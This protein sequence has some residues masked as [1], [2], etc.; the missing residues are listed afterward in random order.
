ML[1]RSPL[2]RMSAA[3]LVAMSAASAQ[4][5]DFE[6][7]GSRYAVDF[8]QSI[9]TTLLPNPVD[10]ALPPQEFGR[11]INDVERVFLNEAGDVYVNLELDKNEVINRFRRDLWAYSANSVVDGIVDPIVMNTDD[12]VSV[13]PDT[14]VAP[15]PETIFLYSQDQWAF[16]TADGLLV[17]SQMQQELV[18]KQKSTGERIELISGVSTG[19]PQGT[20]IYDTFNNGVS[21]STTLGGANI[22]A[23]ST[24]TTP[25]ISHAVKAF[26]PSQNQALVEGEAANGD[27]AFYLV[28]TTGSSST[29]DRIVGDGDTIN[30]VGGSTATVDN[31]FSPRYRADAHGFTGVISDDPN[32]AGEQTLY[33]PTVGGDWFEA[34]TTNEAISG[35]PSR[36][37]I[38]F[39]A[40]DAY[41]VDENGRI[42]A[43]VISENASSREDPSLM[44]IDPNAGTSEIVGF[45]GQALTDNTGRVIPDDP[46]G[47]IENSVTFGLNGTV[48]FTG[49]VIDAPGDFGSAADAVFQYDPATGELTAP[50]YEGMTIP[51]TNL[52][53]KATDLEQIAFNQ[54]LGI[55][56]VIDTVDNFGSSDY[57]A[58]YFDVDGNVSPLLLPSDELVLNG[59]T[60]VVG[61]DLRLASGWGEY[62]SLTDSGYF[63]V[64]I[65]DDQVGT[66]VLQLAIPEPATAM[67]LLAGG[68]LI[69]MR[70]RSA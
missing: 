37:L 56:L 52:E 55:G 54:S 10:P 46:A 33:V 59:E 3:S 27:V 8:N 57:A 43:I 1:L 61:D 58:F 65:N 21:R 2:A 26:L 31:I 42:A 18:E 67:L 30:L 68:G 29:P 40:N 5:A 34:A 49:F 4:A 64:G 6:V 66:A 23:G 62:N 17:R 48:M 25:A 47:I 36:N 24:D 53:V 28:D 12:P 50:I 20:L 9:V 32:A 15:P 41:A 19:N 69:A 13:I 60:F 16:P 38:G 51:G 39:Q 35:T 7:I 44:L 45:P 11:T 14:F 63:A 70:R 22:D